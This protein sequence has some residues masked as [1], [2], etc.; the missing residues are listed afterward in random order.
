M[1]E[2]DALWV[3]NPAGQRASGEWIDD[4]LRERAAERGMLGK[5]TL[6]ADFPRQRIEVIRAAD[7]FGTVNEVFYRRGWTDGLPIVPPTLGR[8]DEMLARAGRGRNDV[9]GEL[10]P[11][12]GV[13][14][15]E[16]IAV[17]A[18]MAGCR[19]EH[20]LLVIAAVE[21][22]VDP[23]FNLR[24]VQTT[25]ENVT[26]LLIVSG[27]AAAELEINASFGAL[28]PGWRANA[29]IGRALRLAMNNIGRWMGRRGVARWAWQSRTLHSGAG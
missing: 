9:V 13:A 28:G 18:V 23:V 26:P 6:A 19:P 7:P 17:N 21:A 10:E 29:T 15:V 2:R 1:A 3:L 5:I 11:L 25:D 16:K 20:L 22:I 14:T 8:V 4:T 12:G 27:R 24:G